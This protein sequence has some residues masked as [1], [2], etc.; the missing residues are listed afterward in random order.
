MEGEFLKLSII[1]VCYNASATIEKTILSVLNQGYKNL[2]YIIIDGKSKDNTLEIVKKY[3]QSIS[4][5]ISETD[6]GPF[7]AMNKG[8]TL[9]TGNLI[10]I[11]NADDWYEPDTF[12]R[13]TNIFISHVKPD[14]ISGTMQ[15]WEGDK[16]AKLSI[17]TLSRLK[18]EMSLNHPAVFVR[19]STYKR[20]G[21]FDLKYKFAADYELMLRFYMKGASFYIDNKTLSNMRLDGLSDRNWKAS[22]YEVSKIKSVYISPL[23]C[24]L[25]YLEI[26]FKES[27][28]RNLK[29]AGLYN[30][31]KIYKNLVAGVLG[32]EKRFNS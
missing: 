12:T 10:G 9:A 4:I 2:E 24:K 22:L 19:S 30:L 29:N 8:I 15:Y 3:E 18:K 17:A 28:V 23:V 1:T 6:Q 25:Q 26:F 16:K 5:L 31:Y 21:D 32:N 11:I 20:L 13:V 27:L 7:D 14:V